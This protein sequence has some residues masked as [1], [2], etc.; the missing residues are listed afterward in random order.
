VSEEGSPREGLLAL[1][2]GAFGGASK[3]GV[4]ASL[5][6]AFE[7]SVRAVERVAPYSVRLARLRRGARSSLPCRRSCRRGP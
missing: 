2:K 5:L 3:E 6:S 7:G 1:G 4:S